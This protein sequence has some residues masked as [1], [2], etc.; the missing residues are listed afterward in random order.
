MGEFAIETFDL[1]KCFGELV[2]VDH[3]NFKVK[4]GE[5]FGFLGPNGAGKTTTINCL[6]TLLQPSKGTAI[7]AGYD[8][9]KEPDAVRA[10]I[11]VIPQEVALESRL[12]ARE[13]LEFHAE[14]YHVPRAEYSRLIPELLDLVQLS[15]RANDTIR[16]FS[17]GMKRRLEI[18]KAFLHQPKLIFMDEPTLGLDIQTRQVIW[19]YIH[20]LREKG[21]TIFLTTHYMEEADA[22]CD[23]I[24]IIDNGRIIALGTSSELK[25]KI[26]KGTVIDI[27]ISGPVEAFVKAVKDLDHIPIV[28]QDTIRLVAA[29]GEQLIPKLIHIA[30]KTGVSINSIGMYEPTLEDVFIHYTGRRIREEGPEI[31]KILRR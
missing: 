21:V 28:N 26:G 11:G 30:E 27:K 31:R 4:Y 29:N 24:A 17:S 20:S 3:I 16:T 13:N 23:R 14:L 25:N 12:T 19:K 15:D 10:S 9:I 7:V 2:A 1:T 6:I 18:A 5:I 8:I 22:L